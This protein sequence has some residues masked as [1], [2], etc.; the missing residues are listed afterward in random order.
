MNMFEAINNYD[1]DEVISTWAADNL[2][3][4]VS[5]LKFTVVVK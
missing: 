1:F 2:A 5:N 4:A 3:E